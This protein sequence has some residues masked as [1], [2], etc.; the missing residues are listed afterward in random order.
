VG[1]G[2]SRARAAAAAAFFSEGITF[3]RL[4]FNRTA[5]TAPVFNYLAPDQSAE[6]IW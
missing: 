4:G 1:A 6:E 5:V 2:L 3:D